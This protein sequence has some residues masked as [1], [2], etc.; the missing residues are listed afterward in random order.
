MLFLFKHL[1][2]NG[3]IVEESRT[4]TCKT[5]TGE[6]YGRIGRDVSY[7][8]A[9]LHIAPIIRDWGVFFDNPN[10][11]KVGGEKGLRKK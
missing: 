9:F 8:R 4:C 3:K 1:N 7:K 6:G 5:L 11:S 10:D 2:G